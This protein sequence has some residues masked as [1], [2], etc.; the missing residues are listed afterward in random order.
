[1]SNRI[2]ALLAVATCGAALSACGSSSSNKGTGATRATTST[3]T[4]AKTTRAK[5]TATPTRPRPGFLN[6]VTLA[7]AV[8]MKVNTDPKN[9]IGKVGVQ[10]EGAISCDEE[11]SN[12]RKFECTGVSEGGGPHGLGGSVT[13]K[14][15]VSA[16]GSSWTG[17]AD[18]E[19]QKSE[20]AG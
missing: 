9:A 13:V 1:M 17:A 18:Y 7:K 12:P 14:V 10:G 4:Q 16:D 6:P 5:T 2:L 8:E 20:A 3:P 19:Y 11:D 15:T